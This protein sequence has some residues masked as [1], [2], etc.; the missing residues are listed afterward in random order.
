VA[1]DAEPPIEPARVTVL[2]AQMVWSP[3]AFTVAIALIV[4]VT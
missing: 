1:L 2:P 4:I 3:P